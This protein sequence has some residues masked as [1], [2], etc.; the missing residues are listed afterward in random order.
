MIA[1]TDANIHYFCGFFSQGEQGPT[2]PK[3]TKGDKGGPGPIGDKGKKVG[4]FV[5]LQ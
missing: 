3:G 5:Y 4:T 2:G 1:K